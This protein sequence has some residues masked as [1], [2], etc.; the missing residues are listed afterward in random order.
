MGNFPA[1]TALILAGGQSSR[2]GEDKAFL[3]FQGVSFLENTCRIAG[4]CAV[5]VYVITPWPERYELIV[6]KSCGIINEPLPTQGP[7]LAFALGLSVVTTDWILLL[8]CDLPLL[9]A[10]TVQK[11]SR[12]LAT[13]PENAIA[14]I[15]RR[16]NRW[17]PL[18]GFYHHRCLESL[19]AYIN[20][21]GTSFQKWL[22]VSPVEELII[23]N[24]E[25]LFNCNTPEDLEIIINS[26]EIGS[27]KN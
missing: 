25:V 27:E 2:M 22:N 20:Q 9:T 7:L 10:E 13:V 5:Q 3:S 12:L 15:P 11:W 26:P 18:C 4:D 19:T 14:W 23:E 17:E 6:P 1:L 21:G 16:G 24:S 8:A